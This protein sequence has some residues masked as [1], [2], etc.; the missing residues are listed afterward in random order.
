MGFRLLFNKFWKVLPFPVGR[1]SRSLKRNFRTS[2]NANTIGDLTGSGISCCIHYPSSIHLQK[3]YR[4]LGLQKGTFPIVE[5]YADELFS[6]MNP[7]KFFYRSR[8]IL[9]FIS[10]VTSLFYRFGVTSHRMETHLRTITDICKSHG[11][12]PTFPITAVTLNRHPKPIKELQSRGVEFAVHGFVHTDYTQLSLAEHREHFRRAIDIFKQ[13]GIHYTGFRSPY[14]RAN[15]ATLDAVTELRFDWD[16]NVVVHWPVVNKTD[17]SPAAWRAYEK[18]LNLYSSNPVQ[19]YRVIPRTK[20]GLTEIP[21]SIPDD[22]ACVDRL[23]IKNDNEKIFQ[24]WRDILH[25]SYN[26]GEI[27]VLQLHHERVPYCSY[28]L[29]NVLDEV[30]SLNPKVFKGKLS[31]I[32]Q[33]WGKRCQSR[34]D[35]QVVGSK[36]IINFIGP[37]DATLLCRGMQ[38]EEVKPFFSNYFCTKRRIFSGTGTLPA[39]FVT[40]RSHPSWKAFVSEEGF[41]LIQ[42]LNG[43]RAAYVFDE[44][45]E[46]T[47]AKAIEILGTIDSSP[48]PLVRIWR[49]PNG[50][51]SALSVTGDIDSLTIQDFFLRFLGR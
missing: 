39:I 16:S 48:A 29:S 3:A 23:G 27:F 1:S 25:Q 28:A 36:Y 44:P 26:R 41:P 35:I 49:W 4:S 34:F 13:H 47:E 46:T 20:G 51:R 50:C 6:L 5:Q 38:S 18:V 37:D 9:N 31:T 8:G 21:V 40:E 15:Q 10:R 17:F 22:E 14:L 11:V 30:D 45:R 32:A 33:W 19:S 2:V 42:N 7:A 12:L 43:E 24:I